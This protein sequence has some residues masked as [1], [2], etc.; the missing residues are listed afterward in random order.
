MSVRLNSAFTECLWP[1]V[2]PWPLQDYYFEKKSR[3]SYR[4]TRVAARCVYTVFCAS[5]ADKIHAATIEKKCLPSICERC[6]Q[7][8]TAFNLTYFWQ[9]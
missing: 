5:A 4:A 3:I 1:K 2:L 7:S 6:L 9:F 8:L